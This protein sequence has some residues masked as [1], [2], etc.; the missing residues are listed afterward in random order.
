MRV[1]LIMVAAAWLASG[2]FAFAQSSQPSNVPRIVYGAAWEPLGFNPLRALDSGS[3][4]AQ[5]LVYEGLVRFD[6]AMKI[7][8]A[9]AKSF[10]VAKDGLSYEF[11]IR[12]GVRFSDGTPLTVDDV[13]ASIKLAQ[14]SISPYKADFGCISSVEASGPD[15]LVLRL[16]EPSAPMLSRLVDLRILPKTIVASSD[17]GNAVLSSHPIGSGPFML[18]RWESGLELVFSPNPYYW[19]KHAD[20]QLV[21]RVVPDKT[22]LAVALQRGE[23]DI[24]SVDAA[25]WNS[26]KDRRNLANKALRLDK[27][28]GARTLYFGFNL[29]KPPF[30]DLNV[31]NAIAASINRNQLAK[32]FFAG[33][34]VVPATDVPKGSWVFNDS[35]PA[36]SFD[37]EKAKAALQRAGYVQSKNYWYKNKTMLALRLVTV[38]DL[39]DVAQL[40]ADDLVRMHIPCEVQVL[41]YSMLRAK[42]LKPGDFDAVLWSRSSG[43]DPEST[44]VWKSGG[45]LNFSGFSDAKVDA[46]L[47]SGRTARNQRERIAIYREMQRIIA[48]QAPWVFLAQPELLL[49]HDEK[50]KNAT[51]PQQE[52]SGLPWDNPLFNAADWNVSR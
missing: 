14:S 41:E 18:T 50:V 38:R 23:L 22:L 24:A 35:I 52:L 21:W 34:A 48:S 13:V 7:V 40:V 26:I 44:L 19:G 4:S 46:L 27:V 25:T 51:S 28:A 12:D 3:Y 20:C 16:S 36:V 15:K 11:Q 5:T 30:N 43:P 49:V 2:A 6:S 32:Q 1:R 42:Y 31:R 45:A 10:S 17:H 47:A 39:Q 8:P 9:I 33:L 29:R 37:P